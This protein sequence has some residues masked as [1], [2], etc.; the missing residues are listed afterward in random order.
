MAALAETTAFVFFRDLVRAAAFVVVVVVVVIVIV[1]VI[2]VRLKAPPPSTSRCEKTDSSTDVGGG[3]IRF[4]TVASSLLS[5]LL[6]SEQVRP[7][8]D[9]AP[10]GWTDGSVSDDDVSLGQ[11]RDSNSKPN[12]AFVDIGVG[13]GS[14]DEGRAGGTGEREHEKMQGAA[15]STQSSKRNTR[16]TSAELPRRLALSVDCRVQ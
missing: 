6:L 9:N 11:A 4:V 14:H 13:L 16:R 2:V 1:V 10:R 7:V 12:W 15:D 8:D 3:F 5:T